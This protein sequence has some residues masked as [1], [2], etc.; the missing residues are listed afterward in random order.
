MEAMSSVTV[1]PTRWIARWLR[2]GDEPGYCFPPPENS[3]YARC[4]QGHI[5]A[6]V[7]SRH[8]LARAVRYGQR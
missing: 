5:F 3:R 7:R 2:D 4:T 1:I 6:I 8:R